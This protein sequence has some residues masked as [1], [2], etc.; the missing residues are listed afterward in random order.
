MTRRPRAGA[1]I[2]AASIIACTDGISEP[3]KVLK[4][5]AQLGI[6]EANMLANASHKPAPDAHVSARV[7][8]GFVAGDI[9][10]MNVPC[11]VG[12]FKGAK[13][14]QSWLD[15]SS[16]YLQ[17]F[18]L[19]NKTSA[20]VLQSLQQFRAELRRHDPTYELCEV[21]T[22]GAKEYDSH[23]ARAWYDGKGVAHT[24]GAP[25][26]PGPR[27]PHQTLCEH[28]WRFLARVVRAN[29]RAARSSRRLA[30]D[31]PRPRLRPRATPASP[32]QATASA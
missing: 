20:A 22:D 4:G 11:E 18:Y 30:H 10:V 7:K 24:S 32:S 19:R 27:A 12:P 21:R 1:G 23:E 9:K 5:L 26:T 8:S 28:A 25:Y 17:V 29:R 15:L 3:E 6:D 16:G 2:S 14:A 13:Y 31:G